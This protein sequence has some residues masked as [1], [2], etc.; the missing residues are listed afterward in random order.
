M[1]F[2]YEHFGKLSTLYR[3]AVMTKQITANGQGKGTNFKQMKHY[4]PG[5]SYP[6]F[7][8]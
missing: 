8:P 6:Y 2:N 5:F 4:M 3:E 7:K 1:P